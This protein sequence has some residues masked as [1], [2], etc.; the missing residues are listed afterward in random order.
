MYIRK[1]IQGSPSLQIQGCVKTVFRKLLSDGTVVVYID[2]LII[3][4]QIGKEGLERLKQELNF[5][6]DY[7]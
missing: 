6:D 3:L 7:G 5:A 1:G 2:D 4:S